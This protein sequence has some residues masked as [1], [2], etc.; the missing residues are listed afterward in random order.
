MKLCDL[1]THTVFSDGT[2][3]PEELVALAKENGLSAV[4]LS[5]HNTVGGLE[6][7]LAAAEREGI[8][9]I[10]ACEIS[11]EYEE[12][13]LHILA[14]FLE[15][16]HYAPLTALLEEASERKRASTRALVSALRDAGYDLTY[17]EAK[18]KTKGLVNRAHIAALL[19]EKGYTAS[20]KEAFSTLLAPKHGFYHPP[21]RLDALDVIAFIRSIG[22]MPILAHPLL[23]LSEEK[24]LEFLPKAKEKGLQGMETRYSLFSEEETA[25]LCKLAESFGILPSGGSD[26]HGENKPTIAL[27]SGKGS[28]CVPY[29][30]LEA[31]KALKESH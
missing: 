11:T 27:G 6:R 8:E 25:R 4:A 17:E 7:F 31:L 5:D 10:A 26:F 21:E 1:H 28:L 9:G 22:A 18:S 14:F 19:T 12:D 24:L 29:A 15:E 13:E 20:V 3:T 30:Y 23:S 16:K 2:C